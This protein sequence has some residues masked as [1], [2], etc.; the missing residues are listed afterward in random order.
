[1]KIIDA[2]NIWIDSKI[3]TEEQ[4]KLMLSAIESRSGDNNKNN[5][6]VAISVIGAILFGIGIIFFV[7]SNWTGMSKFEKNLFIFASTFLIYFVGAYLKYF[8][9]NYP[10]VGSSL[11][12]LSGLLTGSSIFIIAQTYHINAN[13]SSLILLWIILLLPLTYFTRL[14]PL[15]TLIM[16]NIIIFVGMYITEIA[17]GIVGEGIF[18]IAPYIYIFVGFII[19]GIGTLHKLSPQNFN[20]FIKI[21]RFFGINLVLIFILLLTLEFLSSIPIKTDQHLQEYR[22][23]IMFVRIFIPLILINLTVH[24]IGALLLK[25]KSNIKSYESLIYI[26]STIAIIIPI[27][28]PTSSLA[29]VIMY[30]ILFFFVVLGLI[31][32]GYKLEKPYI[33]ALGIFWLT[34]FLIIKYFDFFW[35]LIDRSIFFLLGGLLLIAIS[36]FLE[37]NRRKILVLKNKQNE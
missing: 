34:L 20:W 26:L 9:Q 5:I 2:I 3:I 12:F 8:K 24:I 23:S 6:I 15:I 37:T 16:I 14:V 22:E 29:Y 25:V 31:I 36:L 13:S 28:F 21:F 33:V 1:L 35:D 32:L 17:T 27:Y 10:K 19:Y 18:Y 30:N 11:L 4:S 7:A